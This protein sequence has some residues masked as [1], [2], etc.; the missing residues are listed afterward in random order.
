MNTKEQI[1]KKKDELE[2]L[3][4][5]YKKEQEAHVINIATEYIGKYFITGKT[6]S[7]IEMITITTAEAKSQLHTSEL[8]PYY[9]YT[10]ITYYYRGTKK[11]ENGFWNTEKWKKILTKPISQEDVVELEKIHQNS[12]ESRWKKLNSKVI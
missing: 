1:Q 10:S 11:V 12:L 2:K 7:S 8:K 9:Y 4:K 5:N 3:I 6:N